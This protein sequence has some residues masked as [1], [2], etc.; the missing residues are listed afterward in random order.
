MSALNSET[1]AP[2]PDGSDGAERRPDTAWTLLVVDG[3]AAFHERCRSALADL[4]FRGAGVEVLS[5]FSPADAKALVG[6]HPNLALVLIT[7]EPNGDEAE[8]ELVEHLRG[9]LGNQRT[10]V[11][12]CADRVDGAFERSVVLRHEIN[13]FRTR[14]EL[15]GDRLCT[16][17][18]E[19]LRAYASALSLESNYKMM[20]ATT[21]IFA[22]KS[23]SM[24]YFNMLLQLDAMLDHGRNSLLCVRDPNRDGPDLMV[25]AAS[26]RFMPWMRGPLDRL[27]DEAVAT[28]V[29]R[30][31]ATGE[32]VHTPEH[33]LFRILARRDV[34][35]VAYAERAR[36]SVPIDRKL[37]EVFR[38]KAAT[39]LNNLLL[40]EE[41]NAAQQATVRAFAS[42]ADHSDQSDSGHLS[43]FERMCTATA[44]KM[45]ERQFYPK[46]VDRYLVEQIG[47]ASTLHD[48]G[49][50]RIPESILSNVDELMED[51]YQVIHL[52]PKI[53]HDILRTAATPL[54]GRSLLSV[55][56]DI[57]RGHHERYDGSGYPDRLKGDAVPVS[58]RIAGVVDIFDA[59]V[60]DRVHR[61]AWPVPDALRWLQARAG[62]EFDPKVVEAFVEAIG[63][64]LASEPQ[65]F[66]TPKA[67]PADRGL[68]PRL[69]ALAT[70]LIRGIPSETVDANMDTHR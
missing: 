37:V 25:K 10:R 52:H 43:R 1:G 48:I 61:T 31:A 21:G 22:L 15:T 46:E 36:D 47:L 65:F 17:V 66:P 67:L 18:I 63:D 38:D 35:V 27:E 33:C 7:V 8:L 29:R 28:A 16:V 5:A 20:V 56:A 13:E 54:S 57:A 50:Y 4:A 44:A 53:G 68:G 9:T 69:M 11:V 62:K 19:S 42:I 30:V 3:D 26:G 59:L 32:T 24:F 14:A 40:T 55:A 2:P 39:A 45:L 23:Q 60:T 58:A 64:I 51:D 70:R 6:A 34:L 49:L 12:V 41:L